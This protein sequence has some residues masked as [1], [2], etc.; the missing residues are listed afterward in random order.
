ME[1]VDE[2]VDES[3]DGAQVN[4]EYQGW[5]NRE[6]WNVALWLCNE[7]VIYSAMRGYQTYRDPYRCL[8]GDLRKVF[9]FTTT[10][11]G[12]SLW[13]PRL[14]IERLDQVVRLED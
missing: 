4:T 1:T 8:R 7:Y 5:T 11:D 2:T 3:V 12:V 6:T 13:D 14:D 9:K 10:P